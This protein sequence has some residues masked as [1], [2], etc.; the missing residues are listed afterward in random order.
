MEVKTCWLREVT[1]LTVYKVFI[2]KS[3]STTKLLAFSN[4]SICVILLN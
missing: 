3:N 1:T 2:Y 4:L